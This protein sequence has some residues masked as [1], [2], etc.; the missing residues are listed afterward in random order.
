MTNERTGAH[1]RWY[2]KPVTIII[3]ILVVGP[4]ALPLVWA[5]PALK[6]WEKL[7][8]T[9]LLVLLSI[10]LFRAFSNLVTIFQHEMQ[11]LRAI[12]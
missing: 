10:W 9:L 1:A 5:S 11:E 6:R 8:I 4:F 12:R 2:F 7:A 3:A